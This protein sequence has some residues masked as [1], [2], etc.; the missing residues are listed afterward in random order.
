MRKYILLLCIAILLT[1]CTRVDNQ[2]EYSKI[3]NE[4]IN[5]STR[6]TNTTTKGYKYYLPK[7]ASLIYNSNFNQKIRILEH[8]LYLYVDIVSYYYKKSLTINKSEFN[9]YF[10][11]IANKNKSGYIGINKEDDSYFVKIV[12]NYAKIEFYTDKENLSNLVAYATL[13]AANIEY[14]DILILEIIEDNDIK[15]SDTIYSILKPNDSESKFNE[16]LEEYVQEDE[17]I[18][19]LPD[20]Y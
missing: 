9:Y 11:M 16:Y 18:E 4:I 6:L 20:E 14:N 2:E 17:K 7:G 19:A 13:I 12:Y 3:S 1:G 15:S 8:D 5:N 10:S